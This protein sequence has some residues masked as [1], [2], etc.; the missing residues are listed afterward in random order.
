M[1]I[2][3]TYTS[4][5]NFECPLSTSSMAT[6]S[7]NHVVVDDYCSRKGSASNC[8]GDEAVESCFGLDD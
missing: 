2:G 7:Y 6:G 5:I 3:L 4:C 8:I 1:L